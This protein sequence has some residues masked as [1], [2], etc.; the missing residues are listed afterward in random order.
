MEE[1]DFKRIMKE[2]VN[3]AF[4]LHGFDP[5]NPQE[6]QRNMQYIN[7]MRKG[8]DAV[9]NNVRKT[10]ITVLITT[11][12]PTGLYLVWQTLKGTIKWKK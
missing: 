7:D 3:E 6:S 2:A 8:C 9:K 10:F 5:D 12:L 1:K 11:T 4:A